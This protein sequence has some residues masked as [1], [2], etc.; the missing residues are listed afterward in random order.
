MSL[1][2]SFAA[3][4]SLDDEES[5][6]GVREPG[7][8]RAILDEVKESEHSEGA[9][10]FYYRVTM[11]DYKGSIVRDTLYHPDYAR[12]DSSAPGLARRLRILAGRLGLWDGKPG[13]AVN[14]CWLD[15]IGREVVIQAIEDK[16]KDKGGVERVNY[17][18]D[19]AGIFPLDHHEIPEAVRT[20]LAL[21][22]ARPKDSGSQATTSTAAAHSGPAGKAAKVNYGA[23]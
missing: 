14:V 22:P 5:S 7:F 4:A 17:K 10:D 8:Y 18:P 6:R 3:K 13:E 21:P 12:K 19:F 23:L 15:A 1:T 11:G 9:V 2:T 20:A 16:Y